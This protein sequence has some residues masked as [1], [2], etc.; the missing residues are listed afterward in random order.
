MGRVVSHGGAPRGAAAHPA[1]PRAIRV[2][3]L[4]GARGVARS[5]R[6]YEELHR[7]LFK[8]VH[9]FPRLPDRLPSFEGYGLPR[10]GGYG[11]DERGGFG[12]G[13]QPSQEPPR[14]QLTTS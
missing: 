11:A 2:T 12:F 4:H 10:P 9:A 6:S 7:Y 8:S 13:G 5:C 1:A 3:P 14:K